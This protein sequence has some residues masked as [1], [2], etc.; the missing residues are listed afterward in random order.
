VKKGFRS[1][2]DRYPHDRRGAGRDAGRA[3]L[4]A[5][6]L[7]LPTALDWGG[8]GAGAA[9]LEQG[10]GGD[11]DPFGRT[12]GNRLGFLARTGLSSPSLSTFW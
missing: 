2:S 7:D 12:V 11:A 5:G 3:A 9:A 4:I 8:S 10:L 1:H 6:E